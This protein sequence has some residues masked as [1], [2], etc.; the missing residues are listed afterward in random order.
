MRRRTFLIGASAAALAAAERTAGVYSFGPPLELG[1]PPR[2]AIPAGELWV[3]TTA[4][5][6]PALM[7]FD[8]ETDR[9]LGWFADRI[10]GEWT[11][12]VQAGQPGGAA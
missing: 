4:A 9:L 6:R 8:G 12:F 10:D 11:R 2:P 5:D 7:I 1:V 3:D